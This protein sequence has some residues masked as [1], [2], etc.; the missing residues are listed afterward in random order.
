[1]K[2]KWLQRH[3]ENQAE[4]VKTE[5]QF[6]KG[7]AALW[8]LSF[9]NNP[10]GLSWVYQHPAARGAQ[11]CS[12]NSAFFTKPGNCCQTTRRGFDFLPF[13]GQFEEHLLFSWKVKI[14][15]PHSAFLPLRMWNPGFQWSLVRGTVIS[16]AGTGSAE[17]SPKL[18][19]INDLFMLVHMYLSKLWFL[20]DYSASDPSSPVLWAQVLLTS[21]PSGCP[22]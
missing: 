5:N 8:S 3:G 11:G 6:V 21:H 14:N 2:E 18:L 12:G 22:R 7:G 1:M 17:K 4:K 19:L 16:P 9:P 13:G 15:C 10:W 20:E